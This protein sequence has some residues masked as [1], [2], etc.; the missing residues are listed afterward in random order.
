MVFFRSFAVDLYT[1]SYGLF[2]LRRAEHEVNVTGVETEDDFYRGGIE[3]GGLRL[4]GPIARKTP[5][6]QFQMLW[7]GVGMRRIFHQA[8]RR[9]K[10]VGAIIPDVGLGRLNIAIGRSLRPSTRNLAGAVE[11]Q[12]R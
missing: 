6:V 2:F 11:G 7:S 12:L 3:Y 1:K 10:A 4:I 5:L 9:E 8:A